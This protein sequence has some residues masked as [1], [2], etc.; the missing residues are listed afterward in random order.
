MDNKKAKKQTCVSIRPC[1]TRNAEAHN[2]RK[3]RLKG[4]REDLTCQNEYDIRV[5]ISDR[6]REIKSA[7]KIA[8]GQ[9]LQPH[10]NPII[11]L[12]VYGLKTREQAE[13]ISYRIENEIGGQVLHWAIHND[14]GH[15]DR[16]TKIWI[17]NNHGHIAVDLTYWTHDPITAPKRRHGS[18]VKDEEGNVVLETKDRYARRRHLSQED[19]AHLQDIGAEVTGLER[20]TPSSRKHIDSQQYKAIKLKEDIDWLTQQRDEIHATI[21]GL[22]RQREDIEKE[23]VKVEK[24]LNNAYVELRV[25]AETLMSTIDSEMTSMHAVI[26][27]EMKLKLRQQR[28]GLNELV[29]IEP[30]QTRTPKVGLVSAL[31]IVISMAIRTLLELFEIAM[32]KLKKQLADLHKQIRSQSLRQSAQSALTALLDKPANEQTKQL[33]EEN[34]A[35]REANATLIAQNNELLTE[36]KTDQRELSFL[37]SQAS[38]R[39]GLEGRFRDVVIANSNMVKAIDMFASDLQ[40][41]VRPNEIIRL[42]YLG[43]PTLLGQKK[44]ETIK[45]KVNHSQAPKVPGTS[46]KGGLKK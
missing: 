43:I 46:K 35:L 21:D 20:G 19:C 41:K 25:V 5:P 15:E 38:A 28:E 3:V 7:Y 40:L 24:Q 14:E 16:K 8:V 4:I 6:M 33:T 45:T 13:T 37:R 30:D 11:E 23:N 10:A 31:A 32:Q 27:P 29:S 42:E 1:N 34:Q 17:P 2:F 18:L 44:W 22:N 36:H 39:E 26:G 9:K 12:V